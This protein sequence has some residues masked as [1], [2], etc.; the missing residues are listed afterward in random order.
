MI[1]HLG[2]WLSQTQPILLG[3]QANKICDDLYEGYDSCFIPNVEYD[4]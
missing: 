4:E 3:S 2:T 1:S